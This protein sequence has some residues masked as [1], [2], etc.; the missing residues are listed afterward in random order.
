M[1][2]KGLKKLR[3]LSP[4]ANIPTEWPPIVGEVSANFWGLV[5]ATWSEQRMPAAVFSSFYAEAATISSK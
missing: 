5:G 1:K 2:E 3:G 4:R